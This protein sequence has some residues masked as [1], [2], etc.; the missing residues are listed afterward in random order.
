MPR[1]YNRLRVLWQTKT[2]VQFYQ[3]AHL[4][5]IFIIEIDNRIKAKPNCNYLQ[6]CLSSNIS[7]INSTKQNVPQN[8][9]TINANLHLLL[10]TLHL[11]TDSFFTNQHCGY[12]HFLSTVCWWASDGEF[13]LRFLLANEVY[14]SI[15]ENHGIIV[16]SAIRHLR[17]TNICRCH[18]FLIYLSSLCLVLMLVSLFI[19]LILGSIQ[20][21]NTMC[22]LNTELTQ[23]NGQHFGN[24]VYQHRTEVKYIYIK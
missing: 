11:K 12:I 10:G 4:L 16:L 13:P 18:H 6:L 7:N 2:R 9:Q 1:L 3:H 22:C 14:E 17:I 23:T 20:R 5:D 19:M 8:R 21:F 24:I 15:A